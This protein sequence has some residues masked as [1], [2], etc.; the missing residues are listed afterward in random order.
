MREFN[1]EGRKAGK[2]L[3]ADL[4]PAFLPSLFDHPEPVAR[5][6]RGNRTCSAM[7]PN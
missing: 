2:E 6:A 7:N 5:D 3:S 4:L 1:K